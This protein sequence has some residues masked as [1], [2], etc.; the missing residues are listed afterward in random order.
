VLL[1]LAV[2]SS[3]R[4][5]LFGEPRLPTNPHVSDQDSHVDQDHGYGDDPFDEV[6]RW[7]QRYESDHDKREIQR[8]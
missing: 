7:R 5:C 3:L 2:C 4:W 6:R 1:S 8:Q